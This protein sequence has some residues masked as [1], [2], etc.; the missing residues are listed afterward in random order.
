MNSNV[1]SGFDIAA[2]IA[3]I[4]IDE[5]KS[6]YVTKNFTGL[7]QRY[8]H[9]VEEDFGGRCLIYL[10]TYYFYKTSFGN[11]HESNAYNIPSFA[12]RFHFILFLS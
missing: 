3:S 5:F 12:I 10:I 6:H 4:A 1:T 7:I 8:Y 11:S 2:E 9:L